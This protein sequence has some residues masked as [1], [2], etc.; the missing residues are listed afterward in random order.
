MMAMLKGETGPT[1]LA[2]HKERAM[3]NTILLATVFV[4]GIG[5]GVFAHK[6]L[7]KPP[8]TQAEAGW[9]DTEEDTRAKMLDFQQRLN[10]LEKQSPDTVDKLTKDMEAQRSIDDILIKYREAQQSKYTLLAMAVS[11]ALTGLLG[12][13]SG[14]LGT[15][16]TYRFSK[17]S[18]N[19]TP[20]AATAAH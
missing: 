18:P 3:K 1:R 15:V 10:K 20:R 12:L 14:V 9:N 7:R 19:A 11:G 17:K 13:V 2:D 5:L 16:L 6:T 8:A 4:I